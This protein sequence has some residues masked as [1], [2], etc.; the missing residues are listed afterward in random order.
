MKL[1]VSCPRGRTF[2]SFFDS[3]NIQLACELYDVVWNPYERNMTE[4]EAVDLIIDCDVYM[5]TWG[6]PP[7]TEAFFE[8]SKGLKT[9]AHLGYS[10][11]AFITD[12]V[13]NREV[14]VLSGEEYYFRSAAEGTLAYILAALRAVPEFSQRL[15]YGSEWKH[16]W[17]SGRRLMDKTVG[18]L[19]YNG[20]S[21]RLIELLSVFKVNILVCDE[22]YNITEEEKLGKRIMQVDAKE[23]FSVSDV[24]CIHSPVGGGGYHT[25]GSEL[26]YAIKSDAL[27]VDTSI[28]GIVDREALFGSLV[29]K[30]YTAVLDVYES[31]PPAKND[32]L[33][34]LPNVIPMPH[35]AGPTPDVRPL[36]AREMLIK[37]CR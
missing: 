1:L 25:V 8:A 27:F 24:I 31:E 3:R 37:C 16:S 9:I 14:S 19:N 30:N 33:I 20:I 15:K 7:P 10:A 4:K 5:T 29:Q 26:L 13:L 12:A 11:E 35:M 17:N 21:K 32:P 34:L 28:G 22:K 6:A 2:D 18:I 36:I 23:M